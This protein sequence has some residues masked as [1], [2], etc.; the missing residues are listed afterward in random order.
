MQAQTGILNPG[1]Q[2]RAYEAEAAP[3]LSK[4]RPLENKRAL[5]DFLAG[6][7]R[8]ALRMAEFATRNTDEALDIVQDAMCKLVERYAERPG[9]EWAPLFQTILQSRIMDW[10]RRQSVKSRLFGWLKPKDDE[11]EADVFEQIADPHAKGIAEALSL[12]QESERVAAAVARLPLRQQQAF[13][14]RA[15]E[16]LSVE[17]TARAMGCTAGSVKTHY[18]RALQALRAA[19]ED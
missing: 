1:L 17:D 9:A 5:N 7:E 14:L 8:R 2:W 13:L 12:R 10:H 11:D 15:W 18:F 4:E 6:V 3:A 16:E 19:L